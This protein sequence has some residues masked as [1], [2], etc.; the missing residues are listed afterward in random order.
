MRKGHG[1]EYEVLDYRGQS[2]SNKALTKHLLILAG[3]HISY[4]THQHRSETWVVIEDEG[5]IILNDE[6]LPVHRG[7]TV[8]VTVGAKHAARGITDLHIIE[9]QVGDELT[10][11]D[12]EH[13]EY[14]WTSQDKYERWL[15]AGLMVEELKDMTADEIEDAFGANLHFGTGGLRAV[16]GAGTNRMNV[17][18]VAKASQGLSDH[19]LERNDTPSVAI[20]YDTRHNSELFA[21]TAAEVF[22]ANGIKVHIFD[23]P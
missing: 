3:Q 18:T 5:E 13:L 11:E 21:K 20:A 6:V 23:E 1:E 12:V 17:H 7:D 4:Q 2:G 8:T 15:N 22:V 16:M 14:D 19:L 10:E 9:V